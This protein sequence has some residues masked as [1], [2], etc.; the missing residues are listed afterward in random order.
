[1]YEQL[2]Q[3]LKKTTTF[4]ERAGNDENDMDKHDSAAANDS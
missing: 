1:M 2:N 4:K 3:I